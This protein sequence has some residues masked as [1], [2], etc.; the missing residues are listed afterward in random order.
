M[1]SDPQQDFV[2]CSSTRSLSPA[3]TVRLLETSKALDPGEKKKSHNPNQSA[4]AK[5]SAI[6][7]FLDI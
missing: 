4:T 6:Q 7:T 2:S 3:V 1:Q 5:F